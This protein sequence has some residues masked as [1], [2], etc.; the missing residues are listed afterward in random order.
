MQ[1]RG[2]L[3]LV[4]AAP[5]TK[6]QHHQAHPGAEHEALQT[7]ES[8]LMPANSRR[9]L[10]TRGIRPTA[11]G[12]RAVIARYRGTSQITE[13]EGSVGGRQ[14]RSPTR[15]GRAVTQ[16]LGQPRPSNDDRFHRRPT[17]AITQGY[18]SFPDRFPCR[19]FAFIGGTDRVGCLRAD[20]PIM[21]RWG[22]GLRACASA[23]RALSPGRPGARC[24][25]NNHRFAFWEQPA[26]RHPQRRAAPA[27][28]H[29]QLAPGS[30]RSVTSGVRRSPDGPRR[31]VSTFAAQHEPAGALAGWGWRVSGSEGG[32]AIQFTRTRTWTT[33]PA[34]CRRRRG[35]RRGFGAIS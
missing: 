1:F 27:E 9:E 23:R 30:R 32:G 14:A 25:P 17:A 26:A 33:G 29:G 4:P 2:M 35:P 21:S 31:D 5:S 11:E 10:A 15:A 12:F 18:C 16:R 7:S 6:A 24:R 19:L 13:S 8:S 34:A 20:V 22:P 28:W 3:L